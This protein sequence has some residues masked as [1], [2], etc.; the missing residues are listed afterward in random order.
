M[1]IVAASK[2]IVSTYSNEFDKHYR[3]FRS[4]DPKSVMGKLHKNFN[5]YLMCKV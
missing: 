1:L 4:P 3:D 2:K 5:E